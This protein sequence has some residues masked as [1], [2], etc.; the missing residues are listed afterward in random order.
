[1]NSSSEEGAVWARD[2]VVFRGKSVVPFWP[3]CG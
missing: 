3:E 1:M 2:G